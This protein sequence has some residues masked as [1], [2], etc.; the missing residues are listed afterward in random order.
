MKGRVIGFLF[1]LPFFAMG[2]LFCWFM[3]ISPII[4]SLSSAD[5]PQVPCKIVKSEVESHSSS[6]GTT[7]SVEIEFSYTFETIDYTGGSYDFNDVNSS[8]RSGKQKVVNQYPVGSEATCWVNSKDPAKAV[9]SRR[10]PGIVYIIIPFTSIFMVVGLAIMLGSLGLLPKKWK[11]QSNRK[12]KRTHVSAEEG[13]VDL[14]PSA[15]GWG[16]ALGMLLMAVFWNGIVSVFLWQIVEGFRKGDP[17]WFL[18]IF[19]IPF[20]VVGIGLI[21]GFFYQLLAL[22]NPTL[23]FVL[24]QANPHLGEKIGLQWKS[25]GSLH[26]LSSLRIILEGREAATYSRGTDSVTDHCTFYRSILFETD[27]PSAHSGGELTLE[28]P[29]NLM[30]SFEGG[31]NKI[32]WRLLVDGPIKRWPDLSNDYPFHV[33]PLKNT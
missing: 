23:H 18:T 9:L 8:G 20:V 11:E 27:T 6:D 33:Q 26:R 32:E 19:M 10:I 3:A 1:G 30:H 2:F 17:E 13:Q 24:S 31:H 5:W 28:V 15:S 14:K 25:S 4:K 12:H 29:S 7:Y 22:K 21:A 16:K